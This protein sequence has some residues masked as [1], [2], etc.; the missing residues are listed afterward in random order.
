[1]YNIIILRDYT[2]V[3]YEKNRILLEGVKNFNI[4]QV[5]E[6]GQCFRW[7]K[8]KELNYI[9]VAHGRIIEVIQ[10]DD[11]VT[12]LNSNEEDFRNIWFDYFDLG[13][14]YSA[15]KEALAND[16]ILSKSVEY[17]YG[18]RILKQEP[19]EILISF[20]I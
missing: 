18:I 5:I 19:F 16:E 7:E 11:V 15:V 8:V 2:N 17:G 12:I 3:V 10:D 9:G 1:V 13:R 4:K 20:I 14:D 6:C